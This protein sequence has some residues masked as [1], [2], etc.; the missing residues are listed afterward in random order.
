MQNINV[1]PKWDKVIDGGPNTLPG[2]CILNHYW[3][4]VLA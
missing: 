3:P 1:K 2:T 4:H